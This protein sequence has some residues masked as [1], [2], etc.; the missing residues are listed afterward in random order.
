MFSEKTIMVTGGTG[1]I[2]QYLIRKMCKE[3]P[4]R[5]IVYSRDEEKQYFMQKRF[6]NKNIEYY[7]G[8]VRDYGRILYL[9]DGV[10]Y[11]IHTAAMKQVPIVENNPL[12]AT[13][14]NIM[15]TEN[16]IRA[17]E[18]QHVEKVICFSSDKAVNP[19]NCM[20]MTKAIVE[21]MIKNK[22]HGVDV[23]GIRLGNVLNTN[24]SVFD[25]WNKQIEKN[26][27]ITL[28]SKQMTRYFMR[29]KDVYDLV[30]HALKYG[31]KS[32]I[33]FSK[34][35]IGCMYDVA[36]QICKLNGLG[37]DNIE[38]IGI[39]SG[40]KLKEE[41]FSS[42]EEKNIYVNKGYYHI[43]TKI[44]NNKSIKYTSTNI[45]IKNLMIKNEI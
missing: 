25:L 32:E 15:G 9:L 11:V 2:G 43:S 23:I 30:L 21:R 24:G 8:D 1:S 40:E 7:I 14:I 41:I 17:S 12:E 27:K 42:E 4:K 35:K 39:R 22:N 44:Q 3:N 38:S 33:I 5:I 29:K 28:T 20:G 37:E 18:Y 16:I 10:D 13:E 6:M 34:M 36:K 45:D 26:R 31:K 19:V